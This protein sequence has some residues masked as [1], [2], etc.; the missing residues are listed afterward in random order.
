MS[1]KI[2]L[3]QGSTTQFFHLGIVTANQ[4]GRQLSSEGKD[5][6]LVSA[7]EEAGENQE[8]GVEVVFMCTGEMAMDL[9]K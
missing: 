9:T 7:G 3:Q 5:C 4:P 8:A 6:V 2:F 1:I